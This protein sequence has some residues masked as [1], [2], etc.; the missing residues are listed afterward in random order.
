MRREKALKRRDAL[1]RAKRSGSIVSF[2]NIKESFARSM[3]CIDLVVAQAAPSGGVDGRTAAEY[4]IETWKTATSSSHFGTVAAA[5]PQFQGAGV[6]DDRKL[7]R[8]LRA[9]LS[10][11]LS[12][13]HLSKS[14]PNLA[15]FDVRNKV[16][17]T[18]SDEVLTC[19]RSAFTHLGLWRMLYDC[20]RPK[21]RA[22]NKCL[23]KR[24][25]LTFSSISDRLATISKGAFRPSVWSLW[26][27]DRPIR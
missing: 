12:N 2:G 26:V 9:T 25:L 6:D 16:I 20:S 1:E 18:M 14:N 3:S 21:F 8:A 15:A 7:G 11:R 24:A 4:F 23:V 17:T 19:V 10:G 13:L 5:G 27:G 22:I